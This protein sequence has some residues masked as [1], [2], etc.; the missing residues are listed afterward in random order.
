MSGSKHK[1]ESSSQGAENKGTV[2]EVITTIP[3]LT[4]IKLD[5]DGENYVEWKYLVE[6]SLGGMGKSKSNSRYANSVSQP[7]TVPHQKEGST[8]IMFDEEFN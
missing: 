8:M 7:D 1:E 3:K 2:T 5:G 4:I 6:V